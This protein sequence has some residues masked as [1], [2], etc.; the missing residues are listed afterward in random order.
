MLKSIFISRELKELFNKV[1]NIFSLSRLE[2]YY[3]VAFN[4]VLR[5]INFEIKGDG[6]FPKLSQ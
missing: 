5:K 4:F 1:R 6:F 2:K 3:D